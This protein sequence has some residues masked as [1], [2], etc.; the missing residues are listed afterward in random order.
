MNMRQQAERFGAVVDDEVIKVDFKKR[1]FT[2]TTHAETY[3]AEATLVCTGASP[4][5]PWYSCWAIV[6]RGVSYCALA[7]AHSSKAKTL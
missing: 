3:T 1:P 2:I 4:R 6:R 7:M 5:K